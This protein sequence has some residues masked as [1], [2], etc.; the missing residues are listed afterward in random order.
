MW[1]LLDHKVLP[2]A[3]IIGIAVFIAAWF[4]FSIFF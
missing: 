1:N 2:Y 3:I 4:A